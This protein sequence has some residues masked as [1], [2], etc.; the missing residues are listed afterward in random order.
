MSTL[1]FIIQQ[2]LFFAVPLLVVALGAL[3]SEKSGV[4][5]IGLEGIMIVGAFAGILTINALGAT[6]SGQL[7]YTIAIIVAA[8]IGGLF[9]LIHA[10]TSIRLQADQTISGTALN[11]F[12]PA[13]CLFITRTLYGTNQITFVDTFFIE[14]VP[15]LGD[16]PF[17]G[18][19]LFKNVYLSTYVGFGLLIIF[20]YL[21]N[22]TAFG[23]RLS[24]CG[25]NPQAAASVGVSVSRLRYIGVLVSGLLAGAGGLTLI[26]TTST[27]F[28]SSVA[29]Y[30][31]LALAVLILAQ[32]KPMGI[33]FGSLFFGIMKAI[34][35]SYAAIPFLASMQVDSEIFKMLP[36][37]LTI[38]V[39]IVSSKNSLAPK[40][41]S[42]PYDDGN[43]FRNSNISNKNRRIMWV[44]NL[45][46]FV[47]ITALIM[48]FTLKRNESSFVSEGF[49]ADV[50][51]VIDST[52]T[53]DDK[54]Y[55]QGIWEGMGDYSKN[56]GDT[57][58]YYKAKDNS[59]D[60][61]YDCIKLAIL[62]N[63]KTVVIPNNM[64]VTALC[65][66][67]D[68]Y[69]DVNFIFLDGVITDE[70]GNTVL[71]DNLACFETAEEQSGFLAGYSAVMDGYRSLGFMG[72]MAIPAVTDF[73]YGFVQGAEYAGKQLGLSDKEISIKYQYMGVF[74]ATPEVLAAASSWYRS[75]TEVIFACGGPLGNSVM[76]AAET[77]NGKV[78]GVDTDQSVESE[79]VITSAMKNLKDSVYIL[80]NKNKKDELNYGKISGLTAAEETVK[81]PM[82][83]SKFNS[84]NQQQYDEIYSKL[85]NK[86]IELKVFSDAQTANDLPL[87][88]VD[89]QTI[90]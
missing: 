27:N 12:A 1:Y 83:T 31:F 82:E 72:G 35:S 7:L 23:L 41:V 55:I 47:L 29:G 15:F 66:I 90:D 20:N 43:G 39:L 28:S 32:W 87:Q 80:L 52:S 6:L 76:K 14:K 85:A 75:G 48:N 42:I 16:I 79:T 62:G 78:I 40:A 46:I 17:I 34:S 44:S 26:V 68:E 37:V 11:L 77:N 25:E 59:N 24:A 18:D 8:L 56:S 70:N 54:S 38:L 50:A 53:I 33:L 58:K 13:V 71:R 57:I 21:L 36:Y 4:S 51:I 3:Y 86:Q 5:N 30:G 19:C 22:K 88:V 89:I 65:K 2:A 74:E 45:L 64:F 49:G 84:F 63:A 69:P 9:S 81:L 61:L 73:G 10:Y 67:Q 60:S